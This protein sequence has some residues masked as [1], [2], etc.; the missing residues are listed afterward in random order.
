MLRIIK[1]FNAEEKVKQAEQAKQDLKSS[2]EEAKA[3]KAV[4]EGLAAT[5]AELA[6]GI[7]QM[8]ESAA[9][10]AQSVR[11]EK[12]E[13]L[14]KKLE[15]EKQNREALASLAEMAEA[16][17]NRNV[18]ENVAATAVETL[19]VA[20]QALKKVVTALANAAL[21]WRS[22]EDFCKRLSTP[23]LANLI[24]DLEELEPDD[25]VEGYKTDP[26]FMQTAVVYLAKWVALKEVCDEYVV[27][28]IRA[29]EIVEGNIKAAPRI[30]E[31]K[32]QA[33]RL[34]AELLDTVQ[35]QQALNVAATNQLEG[36]RAA[37]EV[38]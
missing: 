20:I 8:Q 2:Q 22:M 36:E 24:K 21:F 11:T 15:M 23:E 29:R 14:N 37:L 5:F 28:T 4:A 32:Q 3:K 6:K 17:K 9:A 35:Q 18:E 12:L 19:H 38:N 7:Q 16:I 34:A 30:D 10:A 31:A 13:Y 1:G 27:A 33:P 25:R 26:E